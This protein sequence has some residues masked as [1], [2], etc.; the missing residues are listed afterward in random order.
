MLC[1]A[2]GNF[3]SFNNDGGIINFLEI[4]LERKLIY[5]SNEKLSEEI[6]SLISWL[7]CMFVIVLRPEP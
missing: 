4:L 1:F 3:K 7:D 5:T 2:N 6:V